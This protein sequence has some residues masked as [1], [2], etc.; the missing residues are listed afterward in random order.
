MIKFA[1]EHKAKQEARVTSDYNA[2]AEKLGSFQV[3]KFALPILAQAKESPGSTVLG[4]LAPAAPAIAL[5]S[6]AK[7]KHAS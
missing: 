3:L 7:A 2:L 1:A 6:Q 4:P 5:A